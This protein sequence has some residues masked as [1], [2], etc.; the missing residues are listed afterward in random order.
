MGKV[1]KRRQKVTG[2]SDRMERLRQLGEQR[3]GKVEKGEKGE[4][5]DEDWFG[6]VG[7]L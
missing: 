5:Y 2:C 7:V 3:G 4:A 1:L 6:G